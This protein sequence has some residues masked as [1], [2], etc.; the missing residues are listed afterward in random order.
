MH[1]KWEMQKHALKSAG[2]NTYCITATFMDY[3]KLSKNI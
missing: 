1:K 3:S 2:P